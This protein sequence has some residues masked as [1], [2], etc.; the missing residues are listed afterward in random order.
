MT[1]REMAARWVNEATSA[2]ESL[3][4]RQPTG[5]GSEFARFW[6]KVSFPKGGV[7][8]WLWTGAKLKRQGHGSAGAG[9]R[10]TTAH[11]IAWAYLR[12]EVPTGTELDHLC[13]N[14]PCVNPAHLEPVSHAVNCLRG[15]GPTAVNARKT[16]CN[17]GHRYSTETVHVSPKSGYRQ[18]RLCDRITKRARRIARGLP[19]KELKR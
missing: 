2:L 15:V 6:S 11:A 8:C 14:P 4:Q 12:G 7:G 13:R 10:T 19:V 18:C 5:T 1:T 16:H 9:R 3:P 17:R